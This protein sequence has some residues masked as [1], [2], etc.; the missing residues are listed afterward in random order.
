MNYNALQKSILIIGNKDDLLVSNI[1]RALW[2]QFDVIWTSDTDFLHREDVYNAVEAI[3]VCKKISPQ[4]GA[5]LGA[6]IRSCPNLRPVPIFFI[7]DNYQPKEWINSITLGGVELFD[8]AAP[9]DIIIY[10][11][12]GV[13]NYRT[14]FS[15]TKDSMPSG[16]AL[17]VSHNIVSE[18]DKDFV[19]KL[20]KVVDRN[21]SKT[22]FSV[23]DLSDIIGMTS[24]TL[25]R[26]VKRLTGKTVIEFIRDYRLKRAA[27]LIKNSEQP[28]YYVRLRTG[29]SSCSYFS[30]CFRKT[31]GYPPSIYRKI[32]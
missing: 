21:L 11:I 3:L 24:S 28:I 2:F 13:C 31:Y 25:Y 18:R 1:L 8:K 26:K 10:K 12:I 17:N 19:E 22:S 23:S 32:A 15:T 7:L 14:L 27:L 5:I 29:F 6:A 16:L 4:E 9:V 20:E 30:K